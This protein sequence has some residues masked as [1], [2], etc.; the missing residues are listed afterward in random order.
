MPVVLASVPGSIT[1]EQYEESI[2]RL[3]PSGRLESPA[4]LPVEGLL[5]HI[6]G[7][8]P[9]GF[10]VIDVWESEDAVRRFAEILGP[11]LQELGV[12]AQPVVYEAHT[13]VTA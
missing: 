12:V 1:R 11:I 7:E 13:F 3:H 9:D 6:T 8:T 2:R 5:A 4:D 10:R